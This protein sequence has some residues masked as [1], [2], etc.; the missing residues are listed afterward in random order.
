MLKEYCPERWTDLSH[1]HGGH[2]IADIKAATGYSV[3]TVTFH[4]SSEELFAAFRA[5]NFGKSTEENGPAVVFHGSSKAG[6]E[7]ICKGGFDEK[8]LRKDG[9][10][11]NGVYVSPDL[12][13]ALMY[14]EPCKDGKLCVLFGNAHLGDDLARIPVGW[15]AQTDFGKHPDGSDVL[16]LRDPEALYFCMKCE[17]ANNGQ[18]QRQ[19]YFAFSIDTS[20]PPSDFALCHMYY[21][22]AVW[23]EFQKNVPGIVARRKHLRGF[24]TLR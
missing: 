11:G 3:E 18:L 9:V 23:A 17:N 6:I 21:P 22:L 19:G 5:K 16:T 2:L 10:F 20:Q 8:R 13:V 7:G 12:P 1:K 14:A 15:R 24:R 4:P